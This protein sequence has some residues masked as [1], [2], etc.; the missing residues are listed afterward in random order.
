MTSQQIIDK[1]IQIELYRIHPNRNP[2]R[3]ELEWE[4][5]NNFFAKPFKR[6]F[7]NPMDLNY[8]KEYFITNLDCERGS[9]KIKLA[10]VDKLYDYKDFTYRMEGTI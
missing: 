6:E 7:A 2:T 10:G 5:S 9:P 8:D 4:V 3:D 1:L